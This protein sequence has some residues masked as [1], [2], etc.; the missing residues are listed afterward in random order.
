LAAKQQPEPQR[1]LFLFLKA[2]LPEDHGE[3][4]ADRFHSGQGG[5]LQPIMC[6]DKT[7][8]ELGSWNFF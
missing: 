6:V 2:S 5:A 4:E 3:E 1:L 7:A 8:D